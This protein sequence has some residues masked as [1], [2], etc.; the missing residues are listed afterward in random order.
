MKLLII[1]SMQIMY[2]II[3]VWSLEIVNDMYE[4]VLKQVLATH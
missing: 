3:Y 2:C 1:N 4:D